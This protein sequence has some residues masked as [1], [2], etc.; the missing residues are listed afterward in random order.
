M[1]VVVDA[2]VFASA[3]M[4]P[5]GTPA[6]VVNLIVAKEK[7]ELVTTDDILEELR[8]ILFYPKIRKRIQGTDED[9]NFWVEALIII[10]HHC[11]P[12]YHYEQMVLSDA[13][14]DKYLI[15]ALERRASHLISGD[16]HLLEMKQYHDINIVTPTQFLMMD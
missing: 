2:N 12:R 16:R 10:S 4:N 3:L 7:Y 8:R 14:D 13:D 15:A 1:K 6:T 9:L 5:H 11:E